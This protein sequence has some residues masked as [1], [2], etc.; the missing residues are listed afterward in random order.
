MPTLWPTCRLKSAIHL[1]NN[2]NKRPWISMGVHEPPS[3]SVHTCCRSIGGW[4]LAEDNEQDAHHSSV[5]WQ[6]EGPICCMTTLGV[7]RS[8]VGCLCC[9]SCYATHHHLAGVH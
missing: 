8:M 2:S 9:C 5:W 6:G 4:W 1:S 7:S 3:A